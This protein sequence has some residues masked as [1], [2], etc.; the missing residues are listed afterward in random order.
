MEHIESRENQLI[1]DIKKLKDRK[2]RSEKS[3]FLVEGFRACIEAAESN[4]EVPIMLVSANSMEKWNK[5]NMESRIQKNTKVYTI[6]ENIFRTICSTENPQGII[7]VVKIEMKEIDLEGERGFYVLA[8]KVQD[9]G[10]MGTIIRSAHAA[11]ALGVIVTKGTVDVY[12]DKTIRSTMGSI[13]HMPVIED[14]D[15]KKVQ[16]LKKKGFKLLVSSLDTDYNFYDVNMK[17]NMIISV[18]NEGS[19]ISNEI[20]SLADIKVKI[21][22]PGGAESLN[23]AVAASI[24][25][26]EGVRQRKTQ[27]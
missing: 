17:E 5:F 12:N 24:M 25:I 26:F 2:Y 22:M 27:K 15:L 11:A 8:D 14:M 6:S 18:G 20:M 10:N 4:F 3:E 21:P 13:F 9:P 1:K 23:A 16:E 7:A 19:G